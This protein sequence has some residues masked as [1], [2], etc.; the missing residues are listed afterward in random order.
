MRHSTVVLPRAADLTEGYYSINVDGSDRKLT[1]I[2]PL[3]DWLLIVI[4]VSQLNPKL[5]LVSK[6]PTR[7]RQVR[8]KLNS[9]EVEV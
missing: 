7:M 1:I 6:W 9:S 8:R 3:P 4:L 2:E 5:D